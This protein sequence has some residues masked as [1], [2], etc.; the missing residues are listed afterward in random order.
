MATL[1]TFEEFASEMKT[2]QPTRKKNEADQ[3]L[4]C[5]SALHS[6]LFNMMT[7]AAMGR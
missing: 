3:A 5:C 2:K 6:F 4:V 7:A 1:E